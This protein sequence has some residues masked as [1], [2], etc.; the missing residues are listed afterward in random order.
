[1]SDNCTFFEYLDFWYQKEY[2]KNKKISWYKLPAVDDSPHV[3]VGGGDS[4]LPT[5]YR[6]MFGLFNPKT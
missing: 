3:G 1:M 5:R 2:P 6:K 4:H